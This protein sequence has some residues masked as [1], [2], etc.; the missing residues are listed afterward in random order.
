MSGAAHVGANRPG[1]SGAGAPF[2]KA[3]RAAGAATKDRA[4]KRGVAT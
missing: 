1:A 3:Q 4:E 2:R